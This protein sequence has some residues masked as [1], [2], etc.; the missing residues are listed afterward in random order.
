MSPRAACTRLA[1]VAEFLASDC[2][3][4]CSLTEEQI[5]GHLD[6]ASDLAY[7]LS[8]GSVFGLCTGVLRPCRVCWC[9]SCLGCCDIDSIPLRAD[10]IEVTGVTI[11]GDVVDPATYTLLSRGRLV[12]IST[13]GLPPDPWPCHQKLYRA[14]DEA[15]TFGIT[16]TF[17]QDSQPTW[18]KNA[19][20]ELACDMGTHFGDKRSKLPPSVTAVTYQNVSATL[21]S[22]ADALRDD[23]LLA[24]MP[25]VATFL[26][27]V[28]A[29]RQSWAY[30]PTPATAWAFPLS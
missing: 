18:V 14:L 20:I 19:V 6:D 26:Q 21:Q 24:T 28:G 12:R 3:C 15:D 1:S 9:G 8:G 16:Y 29:S 11:D 30:S 23:T 5:G 4:S 22:R 2:G 25:A 17:G 27:L 10:A 7:Q 13:D